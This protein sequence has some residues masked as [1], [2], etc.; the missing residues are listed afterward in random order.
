M[1]FGVFAVTDDMDICFKGEKVSTALR[2]YRAYVENGIAQGRRPELVGDWSVYQRVGLTSRKVY[3]Y[4]VLEKSMPTQ[5]FIDLLL[6][7]YIIDSNC[8]FGR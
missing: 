2:G 4:R 7:V 6:K 1:R 3:K 5:T 8:I